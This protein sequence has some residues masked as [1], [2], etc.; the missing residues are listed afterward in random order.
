[1]PIGDQIGLGVAR[2]AVDPA[3]ALDG[4]AR[5]ELGDPAVDVAVIAEAEDAFQLAKAKELAIH[6][7]WRAKV[8]NPKYRDRTI[9][10]GDPTAPLVI[11][12]ISDAE[13]VEIARRVSIK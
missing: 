9:L 11:A 7:R 6:W 5:A 13:L 1:M 10:A 12:S 2:V 8:V 4:G 3:A